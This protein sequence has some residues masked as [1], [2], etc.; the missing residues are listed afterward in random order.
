[1]AT[2]LLADDDGDLRLLIA[3][4]L[5]QM[6]IRVLQAVDGI[7]AL[8][9]LEQNPG[10]VLVISDIKMPRLDGHRLAE[11]AVQ[12]RPELK[13]LLMTGYPGET[14]TPDALRAREIRTLT[15]PVALERI[16]QVIQEMLARP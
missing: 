3:E 15:K 2:I 10:V 1:V 7:M 8:R 5:S 4:Y 9:V 14:P 13:V 11:K 16:H 6:G 12:M